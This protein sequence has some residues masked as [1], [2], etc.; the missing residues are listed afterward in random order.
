[1]SRQEEYF[2]N[3]SAHPQRVVRPAADGPETAESAKRGGAGRPGA[4]YVAV[5][6]D[7]GTSLLRLQREAGNAAVSRLLDDE[8]GG[9]DGESAVLDVVGKAGAPLDTG[10]RSAME[11]GLGEDFGDVRVHTDGPAAASAKSVQARAYTVGSDVV[12][13]EGAYNPDSRQ[14]LH[15]I[16]HELTHVVQQRSGPVEGTPAA[17]GISVSDP[18]DRFER[19]AE[20]SAERLMSGGGAPAS[21]VAE[22]EPAAGEGTEALVQ[23]EGDV[24]E[25]KDEQRA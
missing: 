4:R 6:A 22:A 14:G 24:D 3:S 1:M 5:P 8:A 13:G 15:T 20:A 19:G 17:G 23:R 7:G 25:D 2:P 16:A 12:F 18:S 11:A 21:Q 9:A 10:V